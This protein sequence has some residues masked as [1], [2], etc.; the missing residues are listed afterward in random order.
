MLADDA[1]SAGGAVASLTRDQVS[2]G[3]SRL[4]VV[5]NLGRRNTH[6]SPIYQAAEGVEAG[7]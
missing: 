2:N 7:T 1:L 3:A 5:L 4:C 6:D